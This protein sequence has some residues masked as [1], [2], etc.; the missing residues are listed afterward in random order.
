[1]I[2]GPKR[3]YIC[4]ACALK[5]PIPV[6]GTCKECIKLYKKATKEVGSKCVRKYALKSRYGENWELAKELLDLL[7]RLRKDKNN[8]NEIN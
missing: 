8:V 2:K 6:Y 5:N 1:M 4:P 3:K 7:K